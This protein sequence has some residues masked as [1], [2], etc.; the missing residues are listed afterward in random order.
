[1]GE[2]EQQ[3]SIRIRQRPRVERL[4]QQQVELHACPVLIRLIVDSAA[5]DRLVEPIGQDR[6]RPGRVTPLR[7]VADAEFD[8]HLPLGAVED[9]GRDE[10]RVLRIATGLDPELAD[11]QLVDLFGEILQAPRQLDG[12]RHEQPDKRD[13]R[14]RLDN[15][16]LDEGAEHLVPLLGLG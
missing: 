2:V 6:L 15:S 3:I 14:R 8:H 9:L 10:P 12:A 13:C 16:G 4:A 1:V 7:E 5:R 11:D